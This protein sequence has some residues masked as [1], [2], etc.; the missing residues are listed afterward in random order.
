MESSNPLMNVY[1]I[2]AVLDTH[3]CSTVADPV[4]FRL[5][6][7]SLDGSRSAGTWCPPPAPDKLLVRKAFITLLPAAADIDTPWLLTDIREEPG[8]DV[9]RIFPDGMGVDDDVVQRLRSL[10]DCIDAW[11]VRKFLSDAFTL[12]RIYH[13]FWTC[14]GS[15]THHH[16]FRGGLAAHSIETAERMAG[17]PGLSATDR[18]FGIAYALLHDIGKIWCYGEDGHL[19]FQQLGHE[20][21]GL[22]QLDNAFHALS[23]SWPDGSV[24]LRSLLSGMWKSKGK[25]PIIAVGKLVQAFDHA[26]VEAD[27]R[28]REGHPHR[29]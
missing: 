11:P 12:T 17:T 5:R 7:H 4:P 27:L 1:R 2:H 28:G 8:A 19:H 3:K 24:A 14:P 20:L 29:P 9:F 22:T 25:R 13:Q 15:Q 23:S 26:S 21:V 6:A 16:A 10:A 18:D